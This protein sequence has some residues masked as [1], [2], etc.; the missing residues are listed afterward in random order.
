MG[1]LRIGG[2]DHACALAAGDQ[3]GHCSWCGLL[4]PP[5][6]RRWCSDS[7]A[8]AFADQHVWPAARAAALDRA[9]WRCERCDSR[10]LRLEVHHSVEVD[11][12][13]GYEP[14]CQHHTEGLEVLC[15]GC[16]ASEHSFRREVERLLVW[17]D[18][19]VSR[20]LVL[21]GVR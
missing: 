3:P 13:D 8:Q 5:R 7:C 9:G 18:G 21:P 17:A 4:L 16:H 10:P 1:I 11:P 6:R 20:Q 15:R 14:G 12:R 19:Q 2:R